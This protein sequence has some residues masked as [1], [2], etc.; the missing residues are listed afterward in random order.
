MLSKKKPKTKKNK[1]H[2]SSA[3]RSSYHHCTLELQIL[4]YNYLSLLEAHICQLFQDVLEDQGFQDRQEALQLHFHQ[5]VP[6][7]LDDQGVHGH[8]HP[9]WGN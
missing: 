2:Y 4:S 8:C 7:D 9:K 1:T 5:V 3:S 6:E